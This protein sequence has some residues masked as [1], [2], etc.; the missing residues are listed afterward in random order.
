VSCF[1]R[2]RQPRHSRVS[3][4]CLALARLL[5]TSAA[6]TASAQSVPF[7]PASTD[8]VLAHV[9]PGTAHASIPQRMQADARLDVALPLAQYYISQARSSGDMRFLGYAESALAHWTASVPPAAP[10]LVLHATILQSRHDFTGALAD[11]DHALRA[12]PEDA[13]AWLTRAT[14]LRVLRRYPEA[15]QSCGH[16]SAA[17]A[18]EVAELCTQS[19]RALSG[20]LRAA[21][22]ATRALSS[23]LLPGPARAWRYSL[24]GEMAVALGDDAAAAHWFGECLAISADDSYTRSAYADLLL[25]RGSPQEALQLL[26]GYESMEPVLLRIAIAQRALKQ[27]GLGSSRATLAQAFTVEEQRGE[28]VHRREQARFLLD[29]MDEPAAALAAARQNWQ[30]QREPED[31]L[32]L[33]R[34]AQAAHDPAALAG[35]AQLVRAQSLEDARLQPYLG[36]SG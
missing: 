21:Y 9:P 22:D 15:L 24:L 17:G 18:T 14:V 27:P 34:A 25:R 31:L 35:A 6:V 20:H 16:L 8:A 1:R 13:Q 36:T 19:V 30:V 7:I 4:G 28:A 5:L 10:A 33:L 29:V 2:I 23:Q 12:S 26:S 32:I 3:R 11:L